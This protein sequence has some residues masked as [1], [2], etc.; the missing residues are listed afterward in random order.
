LE[1]RYVDV[2]VQRW[3]AFTGKAACLL[4]DGRS[5]EAVTAERLADVHVTDPDPPAV[6]AVAVTVVRQNEME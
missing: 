3:Q 2:A 6:Q 5:F 1:P 4:N